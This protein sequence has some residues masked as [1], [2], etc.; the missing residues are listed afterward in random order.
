MGP[1]EL[2]RIRMYADP[3]SWVSNLTIGCACECVLVREIIA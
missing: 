3:V 2:V 1:A